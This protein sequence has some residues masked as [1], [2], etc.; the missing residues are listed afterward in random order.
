[1]PKID[2]HEDMDGWTWQCLECGELAGGFRTPGQAEEA[3]KKHECAPE[4]ES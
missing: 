4:P 2:V 1:M 3:G